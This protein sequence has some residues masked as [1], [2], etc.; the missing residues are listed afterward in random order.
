[1]MRTG[2]QERKRSMQEKLH[3]IITNTEKFRIHSETEIT[4]VGR[5]WKSNKEWKNKMKLGKLAEATG[6]EL[7]IG[8]NNFMM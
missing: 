5:T 8:H 4:L 3:R 1:M 7:F 2:V 6:E